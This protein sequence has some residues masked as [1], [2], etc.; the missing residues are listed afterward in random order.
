[1][2][3]SIAQHL[4]NAPRPELE[5]PR[6]RD[7]RGGEPSGEKGHREKLVAAARHYLRC[8]RKRE[9]G[10]PPRLFADP[11]WDVLLDL[12][13]CASEGKAVTVTDACIAANV[14]TTTALRS[15]SKLE[16]CGLLRRSTDPCDGRRIHLKLSARA[17]QLIAEWLETTFLEAHRQI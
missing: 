9:A 8:R 15:I 16:D 1:M 7:P 6:P 14:P 17:D 5:M 4:S 10:F 3:R 13:A 2:A 11:A 12:F